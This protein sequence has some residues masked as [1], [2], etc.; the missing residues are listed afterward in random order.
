MQLNLVLRDVLR[1]VKY[2][3]CLLFHPIDSFFS[4]FCSEY[5]PDF[6]SL[7]RFRLLHFHVTLHMPAYHHH[8]ICHFTI[9]PLHASPYTCTTH[10]TVYTDF[11]DFS[12]FFRSSVFSERELKFR[13]A[14]C[15]RPSVCRLSSVVCLS[16]VC[17]VRAP[18]S[19]D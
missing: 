4:P 11:T 15:R 19:A 13:F 18:Y 3:T 10:Y 14:I 17:D 6:V 8:H 7:F 2:S 1:H 9:L 5:G 12:D 16:V